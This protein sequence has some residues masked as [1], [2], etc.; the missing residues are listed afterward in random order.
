M[1]SGGEPCHVRWPHVGVS[2]N[3]QSL[4]GN[5]IAEPARLLGDELGHFLKPEPVYIVG[6]V[7]AI[8]M[9]YHDVGHGK[10]VP[11]KI[12]RVAEVKLLINLV[13]LILGRA[14]LRQR[15]GVNLA[16]IIRLHGKPGLFQPFQR[17]KPVIVERLP[18]F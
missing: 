16:V 13:Q 1:G 3:V 10:A 12:R 8:L 18:V 7:P 4:L 2:A 15:G 9:E 5:V 6:R 11:L 14:A 17:L